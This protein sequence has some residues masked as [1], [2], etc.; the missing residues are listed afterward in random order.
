[1]IVSNFT[2]SIIGNLRIFR[3][4]DPAHSG[5]QVGLSGTYVRG[6]DSKIQVRYAS[7]FP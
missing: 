4:D 3:P 2:I 5:N 1:M 6:S 7:A